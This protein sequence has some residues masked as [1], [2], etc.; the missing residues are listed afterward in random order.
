MCFVKK[1]AEPTRAPLRTTELYDKSRIDVKRDWRSGLKPFA[2]LRQ[3]PTDFEREKQP[4]F[5]I[6]KSGC[7]IS[8]IV[9]ILFRDG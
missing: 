2:V 7:I 9:T 8:I 4:L 6:Q 1:R 5:S 3:G